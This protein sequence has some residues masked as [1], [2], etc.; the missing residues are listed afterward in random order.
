MDK[1]FENVT[2]GELTVY[3]DLGAD[4]STVTNSKGEVIAVGHVI[5]IYE[6]IVERYCRIEYQ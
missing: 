3:V 4:W 6:R 5:D 2:L 1:S